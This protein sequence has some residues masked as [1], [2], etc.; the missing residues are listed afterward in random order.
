MP[1]SI[2]KPSGIGR[3]NLGVKPGATPAAGPKKK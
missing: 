1:S 3:D 2:G